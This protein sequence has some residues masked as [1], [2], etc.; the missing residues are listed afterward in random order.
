MDLHLI[1][2][3]LRDQWGID[4]ASDL[5]NFRIVWSPDELEYRTGLFQDF[6]PGTNILI[7]SV[8]ETRLVKKYNYLDPQYVLEQLRPNSNLEIH[9]RLSYEPVWCFGD[10]KQL[11]WRAIELLLHFLRNPRKP[12]TEQQLVGLEQEQIEEDERLMDELLEGQMKF[13]PSYSAYK[14]GDL[15]FVPSNYERNNDKES[16]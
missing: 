7:R 4:V 3:K 9:S 12:F 13:D 6:V 8:N 10:Q 14:D 15:I 1:N 2:Q 16:K 5:P 11:V